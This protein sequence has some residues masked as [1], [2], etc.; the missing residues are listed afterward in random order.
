M[1]IV[2]LTIHCKQLA[3]VYVWCRSYCM[4]WRINRTL[5]LKFQLT[6]AWFGCLLSGITWLIGLRLLQNCGSFTAREPRHNRAVQGEG[7]TAHR[8]TDPWR[9]IIVFGTHSRSR[10]SRWKAKYLHWPHTINASEPPL[11]RLHT[12]MLCRK[13]KIN[14][15][16]NHPCQSHLKS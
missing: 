16:T 5:N 12:R 15:S 14:L 9:V 4:L 10:M 1:N 11:H 13:S 6:F 7:E 2:Y 3:C 8:G